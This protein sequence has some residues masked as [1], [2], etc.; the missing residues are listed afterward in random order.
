VPKTS[1][2]HP[3]P[4]VGATGWAADKVGLAN[5]AW[6]L[7]ADEAILLV[8]MVFMRVVSEPLIEVVT[9]EREVTVEAGR[10]LVEAG[11]VVM[12]VTDKVCT[13]VVRD[14]LIEVVIVDSRVDAGRVVETVCVRVTAGKVIVVKEPEVE[15]V[16]VEAG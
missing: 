12:D 2:S 8:V 15:V 5:G 11:R 1:S 9:V 6:E 16:I 7:G 4:Q 14:P 10:V 3:V 13:I